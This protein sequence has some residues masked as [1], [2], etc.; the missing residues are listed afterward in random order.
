MTCLSSFH[1]PGNETQWPF[2]ILDGRHPSRAAEGACSQTERT[3]GT[4]RETIR[5]RT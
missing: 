4:V 5:E 2:G 1:M 3:G